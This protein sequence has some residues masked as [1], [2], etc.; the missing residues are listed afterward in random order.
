MQT[1]KEIQA[2]LDRA[3]ARPLRRLGQ[4]FLI[5]LNQMRKLLEIA[6]LPPGGSDTVLEVGPGT[7][8]LTEELQ[9]CSAKVVAVE[10]DRRLAGLLRARLIGEPGR[11][12]AGVAPPDESA[13]QHPWRVDRSTNEK[14]V[15]IEGDILADKSTIAPPVLA[16]L[17][18]SARLVANLPY[19]IATSLVAEC[20]LESWRAI[21]TRG[22]RFESLTF[23]V[24]QE[25]AQ[26]FAA[27]AGRQFGPVSVILSLLGKVSLG[28]TIPASSFWPRPKIASQIVRIDFD[29]AAAE[30]L[31]DAAT[32]QALLSMAF[33]Q[34]RK[35][36]SSTAKGRGAPLAPEVF[37]NAL[38]AANID[39]ASRADQIP[40]KNYLTL[41][42]I[43]VT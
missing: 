43:L 26:R 31:H 36:I 19:S 34:R 15:L 8:S 38:A 5:D 33:T 16:E 41:A 37:A 17:G 24:Q 18:H 2:L 4:C 30:K 23:T 21:K 35:R 6:G 42:N 20:M 14:V 7:G 39:P 3:G 32:L 29:A 12:D 27:T 11:Q 28:P 22:V 9:A 40:P 10:I 25:V 13:C 1:V